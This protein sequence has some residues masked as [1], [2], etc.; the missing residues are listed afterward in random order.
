[1]HVDMTEHTQK[2][3]NYECARH[4]G[5]ENNQAGDIQSK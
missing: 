2:S 1:M 3:L 5:R 4:T